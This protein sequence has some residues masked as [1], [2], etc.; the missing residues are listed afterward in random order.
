MLLENIYSL[1]KLKGSWTHPT[2]L[3]VVRRHPPL[4]SIDFP[5]KSN[6]NSLHQSLKNPSFDLLLLDYY[7]VISVVEFVV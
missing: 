4:F 1:T 6:R 2:P 5:F 3:G 7:V